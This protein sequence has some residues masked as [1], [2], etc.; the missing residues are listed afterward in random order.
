[1]NGHL[2][3]RHGGLSTTIQ[4]RGRTGFQS[5]GVP[6]SGALDLPSLRLANALVGNDEGQGALE[7][8]HL[9]PVLQVEADAVR[10]ALAGTGAPIEIREPESRTVPAG[11]SVTL[12]RGAVFRV[13]ATPDTACCYLAVAGGFAVADVFGSQSTYAGGGFG[14]LDGRALGAGDRLPLA[15]DAP[16]PGPERAGPERA[17]A[18]GREAERDAPVR[19]VPGPQADSFTEA[20]LKT[21]LDN[22]YAV[23]RKG[24]RMGIRLDGPKIEHA[25]GFNIPSD[26]IVTGSVQVPGTGLPIVLLADRQTTGGYPKIGTV[27]SAD[28]HRLGRAAPGA[29]IA[30]SAVTADEAESIRRAQEAELN[31]A[32]AS[33]GPV[34]DDGAPPERKLLTENLISGGQWLFEEDPD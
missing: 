20:G 1:M 23:S 30:F 6:V 3:A 31:D 12:R 2:L 33:I 14:G 8:R 17:S 4:D 11:R 9:G 32:I 21:F 27:I 13:G 7:I 28:L 25:G 16:P 29:A 19:I 5:L 24:D 15:T 26:G 22:A 34:A 10:V 18:G